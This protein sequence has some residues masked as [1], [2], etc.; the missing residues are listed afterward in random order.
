MIVIVV[1]MI[2]MLWM[3]TTAEMFVGGEGEILA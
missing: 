2:A 3:R 1:H